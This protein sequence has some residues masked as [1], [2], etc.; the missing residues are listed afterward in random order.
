MLVI[1]SNASSFPNCQVRCSECVIDVGFFL[2][3]RPAQIGNEIAHIS[4]VKIVVRS[5]CWRYAGKICRTASTNDSVFHPTTSYGL[6]VGSLGRNMRLVRDRTVRILP[7]ASPRPHSIL[8]LTSPPRV[9]S[10]MGD[11][12][13]PFGRKVSRRF[14]AASRLAPSLA[15]GYPFRPTKR[16][17]R[18]PGKA[19]C[20]RT[21]MPDRSGA[22]V[23]LAQPP[24][25]FRTCR[26]N[27]CSKC[28]T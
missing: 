3:S 25:F 19:P 21:P 16:S 18:R 8:L 7:S 28:F 15:E 4:M 22:K 17:V 5:R 26:K 6:I 14:P 13:G 24:F 20:S 10:E 11:C 23:A 12:P 1:F 27:R 2:G 9:I